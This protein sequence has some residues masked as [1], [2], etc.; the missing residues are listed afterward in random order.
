MKKVLF[1]LIFVA[2]SLGMAAQSLVYTP[3]LKS[4][5]NDATD[6]MPDVVLSWYAV[7]GSLTLQY[8]LQMDTSMS[9]NSPLLLDITQTLITG[10]QTSNL[11]FNTTYYWRVRAIDGATSPWSEMWNFTIFNTV[12]LFKPTN[13]A[14]NQESNVNLE[15]RTKVG[16]T[17]ISGLTYFNYQAD[18]SMNFN[19]PLLVQGMV[20]GD[21]FKGTTQWLRFGAQY[22]WR[23]QA[24]HSTDAGDWSEPFSFNVLDAVTLSSPNNNSVNQVLDVLLK[25]KAIGGILSYEFEIASDEN[26]NTL[27][28]IG[29]TNKVEV[30]AEFLMFGNDYWWRVRSRHQHDTTG[31]S[32]P[33][34]FT[35]INTVLL[36]SPSN[37]QLNVPLTPIM[38]WTIQTGITGYQLQIATDMGF[39]DIFYDVKPDLLDSETKVT[40]KMAYNTVYYWRMRSFSDGGALADTTN[41]SDPWKFT[42]ISP[43]GIEDPQVAT[44]R[45]YPN[46]AN[47]KA[48]IKVTAKEAAEAQCIVVDLL[49]QTV[50]EQAFTLNMGENTQVLNLDN[51]RK[52][53]YMVRLTIHGETV[54][55]K[56]VVD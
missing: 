11:L 7:T 53:I 28:F 20:A 26:F 38:M 13:N 40:R 17:D 49:G 14:N 50:L 51:L 6:Q 56:L 37:E 9:F 30:N 23:V 32:E 10:Y 16:P 19:S 42:T 8:Q 41:W 43:A 18:T 44:L 31:W 33:R 5:A 54:N 24:G 34:K 36:K 4:P 35:S 2:V 29:E 48:F 45:I 39:T 1:I 12:V 3:A 27:V 47:G 22:Y 25:W 15:W 52:G 46:P 21:V 55:Q